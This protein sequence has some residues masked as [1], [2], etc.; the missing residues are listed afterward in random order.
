MIRNYNYS[1]LELV[2]LVRLAFYDVKKSELRRR[3][4]E[5]VGNKFWNRLGNESVDEFDLNDFEGSYIWRAISE[6]Y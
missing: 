5:I 6:K 1:N 2:F 4:G 3:A